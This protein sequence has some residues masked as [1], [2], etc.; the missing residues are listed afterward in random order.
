[1][2]KMQDGNCDEIAQEKVNRAKSLDNSIWMLPNKSKT[3]LILLK[4]V[5]G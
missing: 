5:S 1:M 3:Y 4:F 2:G